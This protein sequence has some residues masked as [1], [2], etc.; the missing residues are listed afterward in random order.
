MID[1]D[2]ATHKE[3]LKEY[4]QC[5]EDWSKFGGDGFGH[6]MSALHRKITELGGW[7]TKK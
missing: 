6:Y 4:E 7:P 5:E 2:T 3:L 1:I